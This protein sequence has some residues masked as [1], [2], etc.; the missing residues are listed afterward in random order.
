MRNER[1]VK[2][3][4]KKAREQKYSTPFMNDYNDIIA[5]Y[6]EACIAQDYEHTVTCH[7]DI[8]LSN[9]KYEKADDC[10]MIYFYGLMT[11]AL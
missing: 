3:A 7:N 1:T 5:R 2:T 4:R 11:A 8:N 6:N 10:T 9:I